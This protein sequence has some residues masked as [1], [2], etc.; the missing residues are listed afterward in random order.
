MDHPY[1]NVA[2]EESL[3]LLAAIDATVAGAVPL[4]A[5]GPGSELVEQAEAPGLAVLAASFDRNTSLLD[6]L[7]GHSCNNCCFAAL[8]VAL[9]IAA[10]E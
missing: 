9:V 5:A 7:A 1:Q 4:V 10:A 3:P 2:A 6:D 8:A